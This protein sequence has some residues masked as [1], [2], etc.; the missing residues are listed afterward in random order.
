MK[1]ILGIILVFIVLQSSSTIY[2]SGLPQNSLSKWYGQSFQKESGNQSKLVPSDI[3]KT[4]EEVNTF[5]LESLES[6]ESTIVAIIDNQIKEARTGI[7]GY[8]QNSK[9][10]LDQA[11]TELKKVNLNNYVDEEKIEDEIDQD[12]EEVLKEVFGN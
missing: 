12:I 8:K 1:K 11:V 5:L 6:F 3:E 2:A 7:K 9:S 10:Q 4:F